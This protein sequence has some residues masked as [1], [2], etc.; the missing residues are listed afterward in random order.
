MGEK[1]RSEPL[2][3]PSQKVLARKSR[4]PECGCALPIPSCRVLFAEGGE[5]AKLEHGIPLFDCSL[6]AFSGP[7]DAQLTPAN[8]VWGFY[9]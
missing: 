9:D 8:L 7:S 6:G 1:S 2:E 4:D 3:L 5:P